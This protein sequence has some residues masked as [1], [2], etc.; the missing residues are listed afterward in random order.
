MT[1]AGSF[2]LAAFG[3]SS[4]FPD[5]TRAGFELQHRDRVFVRMDP[6]FRPQAAVVLAGEVLYPGE[7]T[8]LRDGERLSEIIARAGG[9]REE[10][11]PKG[12]RLIRNACG[13]ID[14]GAENRRGIL[15][16]CLLR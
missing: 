15:M 8:L 14:G 16:E 10:A 9:L 11:Y 4:V 1:M 2:S 6:S 7:Y 3:F 12:G 5:T 13:R